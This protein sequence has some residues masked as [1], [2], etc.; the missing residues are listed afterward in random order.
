MGLEFKEDSLVFGNR[1]IAPSIRTLAEMRPVLAHPEKEGALPADTPL[2]FMYRQ[3]A[4]FSSIRYDITRIVAHEVCEERNKTFGHTHPKSPDGTPWPEMYEVLEGEAHALL[5]KVSQLGVDDAVLLSARKGE[6]FMV[7][8]GYGHVTI[9][10]GKKELVMANLV[11]G[12]FESDYSQYTQRRGACYYE[13][14][15]GKLVRNNNYGLG[16]ELRK[17]AAVKFSSAFGCFAPFR[18][19]G[20]LEAAKEYGNI[21]FLEKPGM[22]Y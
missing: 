11:S 17:E 13:L 8:P 3:A 5:Q 6:R 2:Y 21:E 15:G 20:L 10:S 7:P 14:S 4:L 22:F 1:K 9:N 18:K 16:F 19:K 12:K